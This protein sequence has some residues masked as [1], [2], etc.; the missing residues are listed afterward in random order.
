MKFYRLS[1]AT[2]YDRINTIYQF[3]KPLLDKKCLFLRNMEPLKV[4][5]TCIPV[6]VCAMLI[7]DESLE[8]EEAIKKIRE[9]RGPGAIQSV[10]VCEQLYCFYQVKGV[11]EYVRTT[12]SDW[13][14]SIETM[15]TSID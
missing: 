13:F 9:L 1:D 10:K 3:I 4:Y 15:C 11:I 7:M 12:G 5:N 14:V 6:A 2:F 8:A